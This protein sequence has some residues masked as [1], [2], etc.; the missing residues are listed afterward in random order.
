M[1]ELI[2]VFAAIALALG[3]ATW[4]RNSNK[5]LALGELAKQLAKQDCSLAI[6]YGVTTFSNLEPDY[7]TAEEVKPLYTITLICGDNRF[8]EVVAKSSLN[9]AK[10]IRKIDAFMLNNKK[11]PVENIRQLLRGL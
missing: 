4:C 5:T 2:S 3:I 1:I 9:K 10:L 8:V 7:G 6:G 11:E